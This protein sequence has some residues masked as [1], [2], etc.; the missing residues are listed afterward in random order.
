LTVTRFRTRDDLIFVGG[1]IWGPRK[2]NGRPVRLVVDTGAAETIIRPE[3]LDE[4]G[5]NPRD[6][7]AI[8]VMRSAVGHEPGYL[9]RVERF[10]GLRHHARG[11]RVHAQDLPDEWSLDGLIGLNF[12]RKFNYE[13][14]S[15]EGRI[16]AER[17]SA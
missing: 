3:I 1:R 15:G 5:Y 9:I 4:L 14:R 12:L 6:G 16:L 13:V 8:T 17:V 11:L 2:P 10:A 7:E